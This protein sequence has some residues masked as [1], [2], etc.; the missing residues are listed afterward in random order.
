[1][2]Y[3]TET[4]NPRKIIEGDGGNFSEAWRKVAARSLGEDGVGHVKGPGRRP[5]RSRIGGGSTA[6]S[7]KG[8][9]RTG[10]LGRDLLHARLIARGTHRHVCVGGE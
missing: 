10:P 7:G 4:R 6:Q 5:R 9:A 2:P 8:A 3:Y 1:M